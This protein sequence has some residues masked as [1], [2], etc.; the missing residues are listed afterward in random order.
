MTA[1]FCYLFHQH[2]G[3]LCVPA[4]IHHAQHQHH[5]VNKFARS[6][7]QFIIACIFIQLAQVTLDTIPKTSHHETCVLGIPPHLVQHPEGF[8][9]NLLGGQSQ[10]G[11]SSFYRPTRI[12]QHVPY[13]ILPPSGTDGFPF[14]S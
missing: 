12:L 6:Q 4:A 14:A 2:H 1:V 8:M 9:E 3:Q 11:E 5:N 10:M 7:L 13:W